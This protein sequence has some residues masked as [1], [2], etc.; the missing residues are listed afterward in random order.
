MPN[1]SCRPV[2]CRV[3]GLAQSSR[4]AL[5]VGNPAAGT[6]IGDAAHHPST[7]DEHGD[8]LKSQ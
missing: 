7:A 4:R 1:M 2:I 6:S 5:I 8:L 3:L